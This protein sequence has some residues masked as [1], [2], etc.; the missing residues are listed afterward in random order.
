MKTNMIFFLIFLTTIFLQQAKAGGTDTNVVWSSFMLPVNDIFNSP[1]GRF[2]YVNQYED[3]RFSKIDAMT[4]VVIDSV[5]G[6]GLISGFSAD[7][8]YIYTHYGTF[9]SIKKLDINTYQAVDS[10]DNLQDITEPNKTFHTSVNVT[11]LKLSQ[12]GRIFVAISYGKYMLAIL[13]A[14]NLEII[15]KLSLIHI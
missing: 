5:I 12:D 10:I 9:A 6:K 14:N 11:D 1:D 2:V 8:K 15:G 13:N 3:S 4:G 7:W